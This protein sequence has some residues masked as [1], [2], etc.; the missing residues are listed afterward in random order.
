MNRAVGVSLNSPSFEAEVNQGLDEFVERGEAT[1]YDLIDKWP[2][3]RTEPEASHL[4]IGAV[5]NDYESCKVLT[6]ITW[7]GDGVIGRN[8]LQLLP[9][10]S[11]PA[12]VDIAA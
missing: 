11:F 2:M 3:L 1:R 4:L 9:E 8:T 12:S 10:R 7:L 6:A 5:N